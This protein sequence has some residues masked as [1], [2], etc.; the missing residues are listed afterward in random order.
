MRWRRG[1]V[2]RDVEDRRGSGLR[3]GVPLGIGGTVVVAVLSLV[4]GTDLFALLG[5]G[6]QAYVDEGGGPVA[7]TPEEDERVEF[8]SF[9][10]DDLQEVW[11]RELEGSGRAYERAR[12]VLFRDAVRSACGVGESA[13]GPFYCPADGKVYL[14]LGFFD[15]LARR[16]G[17]PG[18]FAQAYVVAHEIGH[19]V[20]N[21]L[22][23]AGEVRERQAA[24]PAERNALSVRLELMA[25]C[26]AGVWA[27]ST[28]ERAL[29]EEGDVESAL[30][31]AA[32]IGDDRLQRMGRGRVAPETFTHG[33]SEQ[34][35]AWFRRGMERGEP[36]DCDTFAAAAR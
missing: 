12:L 29:L 21:L 5:T 35:V 7:S 26:L 28:S 17:A 25:D 13:T 24:R 8:V 23:V 30:G 3:A 27:H 31:A 22:G 36:G 14:D 9:V 4:F 18:E 11:T 15:E 16:F 19:H 34:R 10:L 33:T 2:S 20:Q 6:E 1:G 32:A